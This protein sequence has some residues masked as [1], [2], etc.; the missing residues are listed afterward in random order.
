LNRAALREGGAFCL[1][2]DVH[3]MSLRTKDQPFL[4]S[5]EAEAALVYA[6]ICE[7]FGIP[8]TLFVTGKLLLE[9][10]KAVRA[11]ARMEHVELAGHGYDGFRP[12]LAYKLSGRLLGLKNGPR[13][14][15]S[16]QVGK[17]LRLMESRIGV[18]AVSWRNHALRHDRNTADI[19]MRGGIKF[20]SDFVN[21]QCLRPYLSQGLVCVPINTL[22][23]HDHLIHG[24]RTREVLTRAAQRGWIRAENI[25]S[26]EEWLARVLQQV[27]QIVAA[28]GVAT[29]LAHPACM[30]LADEFWTLAAL[31]RGLKAWPAVQMRQ[32][33]PSP[34]SSG[35]APG[36]QLGAPGGPA[37]PII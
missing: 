8:V 24:P 10:D 19:L 29:I 28:G 13:F 5:T 16:Y 27:W 31:C 36:K 12:R 15:Q 7:D 2:G 3:H 25:C 17:T 20:W 9:E 14:W 11:L 22:M 4:K 34:A 32:L 30:A 18:K 33:T 21:Q 37:L 35:Q 23:D 1:T 6:R 26:P